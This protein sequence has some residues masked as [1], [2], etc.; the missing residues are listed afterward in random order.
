[1]D[2]T[3]NASLARDPTMNK[4]AIGFIA[5]FICCACQSTEAPVDWPIGEPEQPVEDPSSS[6]D[7][8]SVDFDN[9]DP[10]EAPFELYRYLAC[11]REDDENLVFSPAA[12]QIALAELAEELDGADGQ[13]IAERLG[14]DSARQLVDDAD[15][16]RA[17]LLERRPEVVDRDRGWF[18][19]WIEE[20]DPQRLWEAVGVEFFSIRC[21]SA[22]SPGCQ[23]HPQNERW[24]ESF[25]DEARGVVD[26]ERS[27]PATQG[28][29]LRGQ[30]PGSMIVSRNEL[31]FYVEKAHKVE[32]KQLFASTHFVAELGDV[33]VLQRSVV[34]EELGFIAIHSTDQSILEL[35][36]QLSSAVVEEWVGALGRASPR[37]GP[38]VSYPAFDV[39]ETV[40]I[41]GFFGLSTPLQNTTRLAMDEEGL[42]FP[43]PIELKTEPLGLVTTERYKRDYYAFERPFIYLVYD[44]V[45]ESIVMMGRIANPSTK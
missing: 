34:G 31:K 24:S 7:C 37:S 18:E 44:Y 3:S 20:E 10:D 42:N 27:M 38:Q 9:W 29:V 40:D 17:D 21:S 5:I 8:P 15:D 14:Y 13:A 23:W 35:E 32:V 1:M 41:A 6:R 45:S 43:D 19:Y 25:L 22:D 39:Q 30:W 4:Y 2:L 36:E 26:D 33:T 28:F 12:I 11:R 16:Y